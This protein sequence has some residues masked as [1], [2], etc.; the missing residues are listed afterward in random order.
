MF[1]AFWRSTLSLR[2]PSP[3]GPLGALCL[4]SLLSFGLTVFVCVRAYGAREMPI[5]VDNQ[6]YFYIAERAASGVP[7][8]VSAFDPKHHL[9]SLIAAAAMRVGRLVGWSDVVASRGASIAMVGIAAGLAWATTRRMSHSPLAA[10]LAVVTTLGLG[11]FLYHG[12][13]SGQPKVFLV[14][15]ML[16]TL[17]ALARRGWFLAGVWSAAAFL[18][19]QPGLVMLGGALLAAVVSGPRFRRWS[20]LFS[21]A[22][23]TQVVRVLCGGL[24]LVVAYEGYFLLNG[25]LREQVFQA[26]T[27]PARYMADRAGGFQGWQ[28]SWE[29]LRQSWTFRFG[30]HEAGVLS[31]LTLAGVL[32][33]LIC[34][35][36]GCRRRHPANG[37]RGKPPTS[38]WR[39]YLRRLAPSAG[40]AAFYR[41]QPA[42]V[43]FGV[44]GLAALA[45]TFRNHQGG[46]DLFFILP[47]VIV[48]FPIGVVA[49]LR[50]LFPGRAAALVYVTALALALVQV[51]HGRARHE[52]YM[53]DLLGSR[54]KFSLD[55]QLA[56]AGEV[57][58]WRDAGRTVFATGCAHLLAFNDMANFVPYSLLFK[59]M[60][61]Y[62]TR[63]GASFYLERDGEL[64][65]IIL[66]SREPFNHF[67]EWLP[68][69][70]RRIKVRR[71]RAQYITVWVQ[72]GEP[73]PENIRVRRR[74]GRTPTTIPEDDESGLPAAP[75]E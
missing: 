42:W 27:F 30:M 31:M 20:E 34:A 59:T 53:A 23:R 13:M 45:F 41:R 39:R 5:L 7:P 68:Q 17:H 37:L 3:R 46:P 35:P 55:D 28:A 71:F 61:G 22:R 65:D 60:E 72:K 49:G 63:E 58:E 15:F 25:A 50:G 73:A 8:H 24:L 62:L 32:I 51:R 4:F 66:L 40:L 64:P 26:Y 69:H 33:G 47:F 54:V 57:R 1:R 44:C 10:H 56:L 6:H 18:C 38:P 9:S 70:Y 14:A 11:E 43:A 36:L 48:G 52:F 21:R 16:A 19:W 74:P 29:R 75:P 67:L 2:D 12:V